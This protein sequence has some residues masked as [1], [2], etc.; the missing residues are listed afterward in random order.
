MKYTMDDAAEYGS[1]KLLK[2]LHI[3]SNHGMYGICN[4]Y[5]C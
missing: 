4:G 1:I 2:W 5:C 3:N